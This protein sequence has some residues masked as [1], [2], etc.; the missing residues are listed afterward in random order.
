MKVNNKEKILDILKETREF[1]SGE[2]ISSKLEIS[3]TAVW[4]NIKNLISL[5]YNIES[6]G[7]GYILKHQDDLIL[8][9]E[10]ENNSNHFIYRKS[11]E[12]TMTLARELII[13]G[14]AL[15][16]SVV[17]TEEQTAGISKDGNIF[18]SPKGG[19]YFTLIADNGFSPDQVNLYPM[20][21]HIAVKKVLESR[22]KSEVEAIWP[23]ETW[24]DGEKISGILHDY[25][26][27]SNKAEWMT[28]GIGI[29]ATKSLPRKEI[30]SEIR[31]EIIGLLQNKNE[32]LSLY[33]K[34]LNII[35][36]TFHGGEVRSIDQL[37]TIT[38]ETKKGPEFVYIGN[39]SREEK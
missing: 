9:Y 13:Q 25:S 20:A 33:I 22:I 8:P 23:F 14:K 32:I 36:T 26:I 3:R 35:N 16:W 27:R 7:N 24:S 2:N 19:V 12:S 37:G 18:K 6:A 1:I 31:E 4:K 38:L 17:L 11:T 10:F 21:A 5:G 28:I 39:S 15:P 34:N 30:I 29:V